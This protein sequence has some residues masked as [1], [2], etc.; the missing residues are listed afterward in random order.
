MKH[1]VKMRALRGKLKKKKKVI[2]EH[3]GTVKDEWAIIG[4]GDETHTKA[5]GGS[6]A[7]W[8]SKKFMADDLYLGC[9]IKYSFSF[10]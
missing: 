4:T 8:G 1:E 3:Y 7:R 5:C 6:P 9:Y 10:T 2:E